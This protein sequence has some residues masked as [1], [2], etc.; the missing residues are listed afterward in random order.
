MFSLLLT[1]QSGTLIS[2]M[3]LSEESILS[4][5]NLPRRKTL[6]FTRVFL[7][8]DVGEGF[9]DRLNFM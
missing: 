5:M 2:L 1:S 3:P 9:L 8:E 7:L 4:S 6:Y